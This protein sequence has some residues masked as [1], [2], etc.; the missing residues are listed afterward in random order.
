M[1]LQSFQKLIPFGFVDDFV[2]LFLVLSP[3]NVVAPKANR[4]AEEAPMLI[5]ES[6]IGQVVA[7][8]LVWQGIPGNS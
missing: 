3:H 7:G 1:Y 5:P 8:A 4:T 6:R 2:S